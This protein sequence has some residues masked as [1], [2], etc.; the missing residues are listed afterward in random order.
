MTETRYFDAPWSTTLRVMTALS[1]AV[2]GGE[3]VLGLALPKIT[4]LVR[5]LL[6]L[7][8]PL[9]IAVA[10]LF[11]V[12]GYEVNHSGLEVARLGWRSRIR[13][14]GLQTVVVDPEATA[15]SFRSCGNGGFFAFTGWYANKRLGR[16][17]LFGTDPKR[18]VVLG[19]ANRKVV[20][21]PDNPE[22]FA[23]KL[24]EWAGIE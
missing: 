17:R 18:A 8:P 22:A 7:I 2:L 23:R 3:M 12:R 14:E 11:T 9:A 16:Y 24:R 21:T 5:L 10:A 6:I 1:C 19:F 13:L 4:L 20:V 15:R